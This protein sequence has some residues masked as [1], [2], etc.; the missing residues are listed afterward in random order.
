VAVALGRRG[1]RVTLATQLGDDAYGDLVRA[2]LSQSYVD[3]VATP[4]ARTSSAVATLDAAG[5]AT[6]TFDI[7]WDPYFQSLPRADVIHVGSFSALGVD[8]PDGTL[9][10]DINVRAALMPPDPAPRVEGIVARSTIVKASDEDL[11]WLYPDR[12]PEDSAAALLELGPSV[13]WV[14]RGERG[15][16]AFS[17]AGHVDVSA[18]AVDVVDTIG[19]GD[20]FAAGLITGWLRWG[21]DWAKVGTFAAQLAAGTTSRRG[22]DPPWADGVDPR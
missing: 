10:Y 8:I 9:S 16:T 22:A 3:V 5:A 11:A 21:D 15:A 20:T 6:Y 13:V 14:T 2:H 7:T 12:A 4:A 19:A 17:S 18:P 1:F